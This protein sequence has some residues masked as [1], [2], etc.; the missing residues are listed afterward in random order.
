G[1]SKLKHVVMVSCDARSFARDAAILV[2]AGFAMN[3]LVAVDQ[4]TQSTHVEI[5]ATFRR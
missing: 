2:S 4:F 3:D 5:A 1:K